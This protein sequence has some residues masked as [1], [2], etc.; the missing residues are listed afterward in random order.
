MSKIIS[1]K[2]QYVFLKGYES[3]NGNIFP[4]MKI[5]YCRNVQE[6]PANPL[7]GDIIVFK[8]I[9]QFWGDGEWVKTGNFLFHNF[10]TCISCGMYVDKGFVKCPHCKTQLRS[11]TYDTSN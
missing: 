2:N 6:L 10:I 9:V 7:V 4:D 3:S 1:S 5:Q 8:N 11:S